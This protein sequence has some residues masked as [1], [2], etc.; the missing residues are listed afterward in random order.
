MLAYHTFLELS[1]AINENEISGEKA[2]LVSRLKS[3]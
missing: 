3:G 2:S 1:S